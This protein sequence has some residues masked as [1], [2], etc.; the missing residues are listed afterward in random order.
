MARAR[1]S[2]SDG[3]ADVVGSMTTPPARPDTCNARATDRAILRPPT[4]P[5]PARRGPRE[6]VVGDLARVD[7]QLL[8]GLDA[9]EFGSGPCR[10]AVDFRLALADLTVELAG[11]AEPVVVPPCDGGR[12][13]QRPNAAHRARDLRCGRVAG[14]HALPGLGHRAPPLGCVCEDRASDQNT[15]IGFTGEPVTRSSTSGAIVS[16]NCQRRYLAQAW[17]SSSRL[18]LSMSHMPMATR[19]TTCRALPIRG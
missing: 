4:G 1:V 11:G 17:L 13:G 6:R 19:L 14:L 10:S 8:E 3:W 18:P 5:A 9:V 7:Q 16:M 12:A 2:R 15:A